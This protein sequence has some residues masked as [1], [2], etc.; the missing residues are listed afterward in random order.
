MDADVV[1]IGAGPAGLAA[2]AELNGRGV[3]VLVLERSDSVAASW[4]GHY[5]RLR[6]NTV[7]WLSHLPGHRIPRRYGPW[8]A[9]DDVVKYLNE[10]AHYHDLTIRYGVEALHIERADGGWR[11]R[12]STDS[13]LDASA[14]VVATGYC[15]TPRIPNWPGCE[16]FP[17]QLMHSSEYKDPGPYLNTNVLVV[18]A[19]NS[20][21]EVATDLAEAAV[22][23]SLAVRTPPQIVPRT[24]AGIPTLLVAVLTRRLPKKVGDIAIRTLQKRL[25]GDLDAY[26]L[27]E[28]K[29][30]L[31]RQFE[32]TDVVPICDPGDFVRHL[33]DGTIAIVPAVHHFDGEEV[34]LQ[35]G[36]RLR[37]DAVIAAT[38]YD[39]GLEPLAAHLG[40]LDREGRPIAHGG[41]THPRAP[42]LHFIGYANPL[43]GNFR[44]LRLEA[45]RVARA[46]ARAKPRRQAWGT[47][48]HPQQFAGPDGKEP[49]QA[50]A[51][52]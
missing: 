43:S 22:N 2:A 15:H 13:F 8:V 35:D 14:V 30:S 17:G 31:S 19:G 46:I 3:N 37:P 29:A 45:R 20:G 24:F 23:V 4:R 39:L 25:I 36:A 7:R 42:E 12:T 28:S 27:P 26:G 32:A 51:A 38:G 52:P 5:D 33:R 50:T 34:V 44:E 6:L 16:L 49:S 41:R 1:V 48:R 9:R 10:Y 21:A 47:S 18:G 40:V 11:I